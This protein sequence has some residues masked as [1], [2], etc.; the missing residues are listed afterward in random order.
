MGCMGTKYDMRWLGGS[1][2]F[3]VNTLLDL[4]TKMILL[5]Q[6]RILKVSDFQAMSGQLSGESV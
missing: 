1:L 6:K 4:W 5:D 2:H 3:L